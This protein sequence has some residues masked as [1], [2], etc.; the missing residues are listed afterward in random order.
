MNL[1]NMIQ[2]TLRGFGYQMRKIDSFE[3]AMEEDFKQFA[4]HCKGYH[5]QSVERLYGLYQGLQYITRSGIPG[6]I[7]ECGVFKGASLM[8]ASLVLKSLGDTSRK[9]YLYD[10]FAGWPEADPAH[11]HIQGASSRQNM[12]FLKHHPVYQGVDIKSVQENIERTGYPAG[13]LVFVKGKVEETIPGTM[14]EKIALLRLDTDWYESVK[15]GLV[16]L[17][18]KL[19]MKGVL[20]IDDYGHWKGAQDAV[21]EYFSERKIPILLQRLDYTGRMAV[22]TAEAS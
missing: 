16:H 19:S 3:P 8:L 2:D 7:V 13:N 9:L 11:D 17:Y 20:I 21:D 18:P 22:K 15:H 14:P 4:T 1:K 12:T 10:T 6:D 5:L